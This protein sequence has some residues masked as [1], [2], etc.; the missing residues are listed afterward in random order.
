[1][2]SPFRDEVR[3]EVLLADHEGLCLLQAWEGLAFQANFASIMYQKC[4][5]CGGVPR[6]LTSHQVYQ[7]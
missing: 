7:L 5:I 6:W 3:F 4:Y 1:M 2:R